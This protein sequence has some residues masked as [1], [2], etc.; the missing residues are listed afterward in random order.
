[1]TWVVHVYQGS[2]RP[3]DSAVETVAMAVFDDFDT[4]REVLTAAGWSC[5]NPKTE[6]AAWED[7][8]HIAVFY[9]DIVEAQ[10]VPKVG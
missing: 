6:P 7:S 4:A 8:L 10:G 3:G 5:R 1:M 2:G 9:A